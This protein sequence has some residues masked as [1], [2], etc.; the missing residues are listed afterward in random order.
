MTFQ[1]IKKDTLYLCVQ[2]ECTHTKPN[3]APPISLCLIDPSQLRNGVS[4]INFAKLCGLI[5]IIK[6][7]KKEKNMVYKSKMGH[8]SEYHFVWEDI[9]LQI[10]MQEKHISQQSKLGS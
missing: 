6:H 8:L 3:Q 9:T 1:P 2:S 7:N 10:C 5:Q 4:E